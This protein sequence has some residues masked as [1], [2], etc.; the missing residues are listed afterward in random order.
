[1]IALFQRLAYF[2]RERVV[3]ERLADGLDRRA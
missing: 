3:Y 1:M 2:D